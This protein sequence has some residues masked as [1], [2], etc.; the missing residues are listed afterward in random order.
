MLVSFALLLLFDQFAFLLVFLI[1]LLYNLSF[2]VVTEGA[3]AIS[4]NGCEAVKHARDCHIDWEKQQGF[5]PYE[6]W[7]KD[8]V[9]YDE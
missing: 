5:D 4:N 1:F 3:S 6:D 7:S 8:M 9:K 2:F